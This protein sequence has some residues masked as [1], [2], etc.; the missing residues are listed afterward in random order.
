MIIVALIWPATALR[1]AGAKQPGRMLRHAS[2]CLSK[3]T[4]RQLFRH[5]WRGAGSAPDR[6]HR[7]T[8]LKYNGSGTIYQQS[9]GSLI[10]V[11]TP[12]FI[13][14]GSLICGWKFT[15]FISF[16]W[17]ALHQLVRRVNMTTSLILPQTTDASGFYG[18]R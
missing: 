5:A 15:S 9:L 18:G 12:A 16:N 14:T 13:P 17:L 10:T 3:T 7:W 4:R 8:G 11:T 1:A 2:L 6:C